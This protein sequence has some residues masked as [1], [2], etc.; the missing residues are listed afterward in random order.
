MVQKPT[1]TP[2]QQQWLGGLQ[3]MTHI[4]QASFQHL[5]TTLANLRPQA[6]PRVGAAGSTSKGT[7]AKTASP[8]PAMPSVQANPALG[9]ANPGIPAVGSPG[10]QGPSMDRTSIMR[11]Q[12]MTNAPQ[13]QNPVAPAMQSPSTPAGPSIWTNPGFLFMLAKLGASI[14]PEGTIGKNLGEATAELN[15]QQAIANFEG[16]QGFVGPVT[17]GQ[18]RFNRMNDIAV[19]YPVRSELRKESDR[20]LERA[21]DRALTMSENEKNRTASAERQQSAQDFA[22]GQTEK[23]IQARKEMAD[24]KAQAG[25]G[26]KPME[27]GDYLKAQQ[28][29]LQAGQLADQSARDRIAKQLQGVAPG[30]GPSDIGNDNSPVWNSLPDDKKQSIL[31]TLALETMK[32]KNRMLAPAKT[33]M[34]WAFPPEMN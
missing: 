29:T 7:G 31:R 19:P 14:S 24:L 8:T 30:L 27:M 26:T 9:M 32:Q 10:T 25:N 21:E 33:A 1:I 23:K 2:E 16:R 12:Y 18:A 20:K 13:V 17:L 34:P 3:G 5:V 22:A 15:Q 6:I 28:Y 11:N 4:P